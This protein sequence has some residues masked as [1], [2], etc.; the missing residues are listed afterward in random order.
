MFYGPLL[1][2]L[3]PKLVY[4]LV[5]ELL[6]WIL[7]SKRGNNYVFRFKRATGYPNLTPYIKTWQV[8]VVLILFAL[9][10]QSFSE[11]IIGNAVN[12]LILGLGD[13]LLYFTIFLI[14]C[15]FLFFYNY[16][17]GKKWDKL[18][19]AAMTVIIVCLFY[20]G[21]LQ[22]LTNLTSKVGG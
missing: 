22:F 11:W 12:D 10:G 14:A 6:F 3:T 2:Y 15:T 8:V 1:I 16:I 18:S 9:F 7:L 20:L 21:A 19:W 4:L 13:K 17:F 5:P